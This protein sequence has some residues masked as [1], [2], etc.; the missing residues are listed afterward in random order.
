MEVKMEV[1][2]GWSQSVSHTTSVLVLPTSYCAF[3]IYYYYLRVLRD[4]N[5]SK[6]KCQDFP[7][8]Y[9][10]SFTRGRVSGG[11][12]MQIR[13]LRLLFKV[14]RL[15]KPGRNAYC[16]KCVLTNKKHELQH[17]AFEKCQFGLE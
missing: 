6:F 7:K 1:A 12:I 3:Y 10:D 16:S 14:Q 5:S 15:R 2:M 4:F 8:L 9:L 17:H 11:Q 13:R